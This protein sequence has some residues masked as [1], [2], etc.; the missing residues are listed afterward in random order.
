MQQQ[1]ENVELGDPET[2]NED[3]Q[4]EESKNDNYAAAPVDTASTSSSEV[5]LQ[6]ETEDNTA[7]DFT[8]AICHD[9]LYEPVTLFCQ[10]S[11]CQ[12]CLVGRPVH[13]CPVCRLALFIPPVFNRWMQSRIIEYYGQEV[14]KRRGEAIAS[15][16]KAEEEIKKR[17]LLERKVEQEMLHRVL[18]T[19]RTRTRTPHSVESLMPDPNSEFHLAAFYSPAPVGIW[20]RCKTSI[21]NRFL[22]N[23]HISVSYTVL[24]TLVS[25]C[26]WR[27]A[28]RLA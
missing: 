3:E 20:E 21:L 25:L 7:R 4:T 10:H 27:H 6:M 9:I 12:S 16:Q 5:A 11:Y 18:E 19:V 8:C 24:T 14:Y 23:P 1:E 15:E 26:L 13:S 28:K 22:D 2:E 17:N